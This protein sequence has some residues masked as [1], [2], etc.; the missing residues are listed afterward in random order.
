MVSFVLKTASQRS[1]T[2][3][4]DVVTEL[5]LTLTDG[6]IGTCRRNVGAGERQASFVQLD[7]PPQPLFREGE[8]WIT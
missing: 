1:G 5:V 8:R 7:I 4:F 2:R 6:V 3:D